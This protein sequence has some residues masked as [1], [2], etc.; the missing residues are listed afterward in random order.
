ME[1]SETKVLPVALTKEQRTRLGV[2]AAE[3]CVAMTEL[4]RWWIDE[5]WSGRTC[6]P[7]NGKVPVVDRKQSTKESGYVDLNKV[8]PVVET[9]SGGQIGVPVD[10]AEVPMKKCHRCSQPFTLDKLTHL[11]I[12]GGKVKPFCDGCI[13]DIKNG[14]A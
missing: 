13:E 3:R 7:V 11:P 5:K 10:P 12:A 6:G 2:M 14:Q 9:P 4:V 1:Q 8:A